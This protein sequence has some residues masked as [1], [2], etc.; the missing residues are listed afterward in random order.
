MHLDGI[1]LVDKA[2]GET[3]FSVVARVKSGLR[4]L[5]VRKIG[6]AGTL[7]PFATGLLVV[8]VGQGTKLSPFLM[9]GKKTYCGTMRLGIE[10]DTMDPDGMVIARQGFSRYSRDEIERV[11]A[12]YEGRLDQ[13]P[14]PFSA[15]KQ[16]GV[17]AY[18]LARRGSPVELSSRTVHV[19]RFSI[20]GVKM[21]FVDF[22]VE[23]S[24]GTYIRRLVSD[25]GKVLGPGA[26]LVAL[27][28]T[29]SGRFHVEEAVPSMSLGKM[30]GERLVK[31]HLRP[32]KESLPD[33][34]GVEVDRRLAEK[35]RQGYQPRREDL[36]LEQGLE[37]YP[38]D[39]I[40]LLQE[41]R[42]VAIVEIKRN[43]GV[44]YERLSITR[45]FS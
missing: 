32:L 41:E 40:K 24:A 10:T 15:V 31:G 29:R 26:H 8:M 4:R 25:I 19:H 22:E 11:A 27:R 12:R 7:D 9:A 5:G 16:N 36:A 13:V 18:K 33:V 6:H 2:A 21:P 17:R 42:L 23:C 35:V 28:R 43:R 1:F 37:A 38:S 45:V 14:P 39:R 30:D 34:P 44:G 3:S 20:K